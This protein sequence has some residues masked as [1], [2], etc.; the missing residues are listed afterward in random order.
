MVVALGVSGCASRGL[1]LAEVNR[2]EAQLVMPKGA[3]LLTSYSRQYSP[4]RVYQSEEELP[5]TTVMSPVEA[6]PE[7][8]TTPVAVGVFVLPG[9][10]GDDPP[11][12]RIGPRSRLP[13][14][15]H[16]GCRAVNVVFDPATGRT[17]G[18]WCNVDQTV[19]PPPPPAEAGTATAL[20]ADR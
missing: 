7:P 18:A 10:W 20:E 6:W 15:F 1:S 14:A 9:V 17:L 2:F 12:V 13:V 4:P 16:G 19:P 8:R 3:E 11:G 5:F